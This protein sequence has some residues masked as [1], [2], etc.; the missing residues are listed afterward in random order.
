MVAT[1]K[2]GVCS[3]V[4]CS[5][6]F[7]ELSLTVLCHFIPKPSYSVLY[8][9]DTYLSGVF[10]NK[11][12]CLLLAWVFSGCAQIG[13]VNTDSN[14]SENSRV[15]TSE[16]NYCQSGEVITNS[17]KDKI[18]L[19]KTMFVSRPYIRLPEDKTARADAEGEIG[20]YAA[21]Y[22]SPAFGE[23]FVDRQG[24]S[25]KIVN[26]KGFKNKI[27]SNIKM[28]SNRMLYT[29]YFISGSSKA[30]SEKNKFE[31]TVKKVTPF[32]QIS[33]AAIDG[34]FSKWAW[35][36]KYKKRN[37]QFQYV[38]QIPL[39]IKMTGTQTPASPGLRKLAEWGNA[40]KLQD[41]DVYTINGVVQNFSNNV[42]DQTGKNCLPAIT[43]S[44]DKNP[45]VGATN[46]NISITRMGAMHID[47][48][49]VAMFEYPKKQN[50]MAPDMLSGNGMDAENRLFHPANFI[51]I[52]DNEDSEWGKLL[53]A[54]HNANKGHKI[55]IYPV[56]PKSDSGGAEC[57]L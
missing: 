49:N 11:K 24:R 2:R 46:A 39:R 41:A 52:N 19:C 22:R 54:P 21:L 31:V 48:D 29:V 9:T 32:I 28:P 17:D 30:T 10:M 16:P 25:F 14:N 51:Q 34:L 23:F 12:T 4:S 42:Y 53:I 26:S 57:H 55:E 13:L 6:F 50:G 35:E 15:P 33:G 45:F 27:F 44:A 43:K 56:N 7:D 20:I 18:Y 1:N 47:G 3:E 37:Q 8:Y 40:R 38:D 5:Y 36:G